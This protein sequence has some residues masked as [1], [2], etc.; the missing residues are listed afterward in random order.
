MS[1]HSLFIV[2]LYSRVPQHQQLL[3]SLWGAVKRG[4]REGQGHE[5]VLKVECRSYHAH[6]AYVYAVEG[7]WG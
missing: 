3:L 2:L 4:K 1:Q 7:V 5:H 6:D